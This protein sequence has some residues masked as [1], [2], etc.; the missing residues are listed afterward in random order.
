MLPGK[1]G[2]EVCRTLR[3]DSQVPIIMLTARG[4]RW[5][6]VEA[7]RLGVNEYVVKPASAQTLRDRLI[8]ILAKPRATVRVG[9][10]Y[11]PE[12][13]KNLPELPRLAPVEPPADGSRF[14]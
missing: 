11:G 14:N 6:V 3:K 8:S 2:F 7:V 1:D 9:D 10:Y 5:R 4:E 12:P 13:R